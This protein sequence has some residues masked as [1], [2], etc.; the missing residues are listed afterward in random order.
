MERNRFLQQ[1]PSEWRGAIGNLFYEAVRSGAQPTRPICSH[2]LA[3]ARQKAQQPPGKVDWQQVVD[4]LLADPEAALDM[5]LYAVQ[6]EHMDPKEKAARKEANAE[7]GRQEHMARRPA[8]E[9]QL[10]FLRRL[11]YSGEVLSMAHASTL[12]EEWKGK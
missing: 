12:I 10:A 4:A 1:F 7:R 6:Q 11:G 3:A 8:T 9:K 5:A 2:V